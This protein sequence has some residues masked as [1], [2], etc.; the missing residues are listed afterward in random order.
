MKKINYIKEGRGEELIEII[1]NDLEKSLSPKRYEHSLS[2]MKKAEELAVKYNQDITSVKLTALA[3]DIAKEMKP[4]EYIKY[5]NKNGIHLKKIDRT[6]I[7]TLHGIIG[8]DMVYKKYGF[9]KKMQEAIYYHTTGKARM[10][11]LD[12]I[13]YIAD[14]IEDTR[15]YEGVKKLRELVE[16]NSIEEAILYD[17]DYITI[18]SMIRRERVIHTNSVEARNDLVCK[19]KK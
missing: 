6:I 2:T 17:I 15:D 8:A 18:P 10:N 13:V 4:E 12:K 1:K 14:K 5:A 3:H 19:I 7:S 11:M 9:N 16:N